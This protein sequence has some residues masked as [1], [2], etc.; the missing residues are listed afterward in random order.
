MIPNDGRRSTPANSTSSERIPPFSEEAEKGML[1]SIF[2]DA[3]KVIGICEQFKI[4]ANSF[5]VPAHRTIFEAQYA[6]VKKGSPADPITVTEILRRIHRLDAVGGGVAL[7]RIVDKTF[8]AANAEYYAELLQNKE[9]LR[10]IIAECRDTEMKCFEEAETPDEIV[11]S[12]NSAISVI[13]SN[14]RIE[15]VPWRESVKQVMTQIS[16]ARGTNRLRGIPTGLRNLDKII[17]GLKKKELVIL[18]ARPSM[19]KSALAMQIAMNIATGI[20]EKDGTPLPVGV[21]SV[22]M[23]K[24]ALIMRTIANMSQVD[25]YRVNSGFTNAVDHAK[26]VEAAAKVAEAKIECDDCGGV[27]ISQI[28]IK[29][30]RMKEKYGVELIVVDY[31]QLLHSKEHARS[32]RPTEVSHISGALKALAKKLDCVVMAL[33]QLNRNFED[34]GKGAKP[35]LSDLRDSGAI[36]QDAD[37]VLLL[38]RPCMYPGDDDA[39]DDTLAIVDVAKQRNGPTGEL[40]LNFQGGYT[41]FTDRVGMGIAAGDGEG[42]TEVMGLDD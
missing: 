35:K 37:T 34:R 3:V 22:E 10:N 16:E 19:G 23:S 17:L 2:M 24:E 6:L 4:T 1:G 8:T 12:H 21:F 11:A 38:R 14:H 28:Q 27:D 41:R 31:L 15:V 36:E 5:Y 42:E 18:A 25:L 29:A 40:R 9:K 32:G 39:D 13:E 30:Q 20:H 7:D 26:M 33:S